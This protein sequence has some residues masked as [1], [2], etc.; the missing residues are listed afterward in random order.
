MN[1]I[2]TTRT[3]VSPD[4]L[5]RFR[6]A[7]LQF[8]RN[9]TPRGSRLLAVKADIAALRK[10][11]FSYRSIGGLLTEN[12]IPASDTCVM[13]FCR[14]VLIEKLSH[15]FPA[16][17]R[18]ARQASPKDLQGAPAK[19]APPVVPATGGTSISPPVPPTSAP[20][21]SRGPRIAIIKLRKPNEKND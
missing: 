18:A 14:R 3:A 7:A 9:A 16:T 21:K 15:K 12:G 11:G 19:A 8:A 17:R 13:R 2:S 10:Q 1:K 20:S 5:N 4:A 6:N